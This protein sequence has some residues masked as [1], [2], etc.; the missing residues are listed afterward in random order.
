MSFSIATTNICVTLR[1]N[2]IKCNEGQPLFPYSIGT[3]LPVMNKN[4]HMIS[5]A[6]FLGNLLTFAKDIIKIHKCLKIPVVTSSS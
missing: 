1:L 5:D 3:K 2:Y 6:A 4:M